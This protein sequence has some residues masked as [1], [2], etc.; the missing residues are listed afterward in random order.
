MLCSTDIYTR[1]WSCNIIM[2]VMTFIPDDLAASQWASQIKTLRSLC[3]IKY[4]PKIRTKPIHSCQQS[5]GCFIHFIIGSGALYAQPYYN[6]V[7][8]GREQ[9]SWI[10]RHYTGDKSTRVE[11]IGRILDK[12]AHHLVLVSEA[13]QDSPNSIHSIFANIIYRYSIYHD[14][15]KWKHFSRYWP[16]V[17]EIHRS[18]VTSLHNGQWRG[19]LILLWSASE[20]TI[21]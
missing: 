17:R 5:T 10:H 21:E 14:V 15:V 6:F 20:S 11:W 4:L 7:F 9:Y 19:V 8:P 18:P 13:G 3:C 16:F 2:L 12:D 1:Y